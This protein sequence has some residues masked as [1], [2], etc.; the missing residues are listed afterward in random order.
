[1]ID[2]SLGSAE[3]VI[4]VGG[5]AI[6][7]AALL[8]IIGEVLNSLTLSCILGRL[9]WPSL[10]SGNKVFT[11]QNLKRSSLVSTKVSRKKK[12]RSKVKVS[13]GR[14]K[15]NRFTSK[16]VTIS[17]SSPQSKYR[18]FRHGTTLENAIDIY[19]TQLWLAGHSLPTGVYVTNTNEIAKQYSGEDGGIV[20]VD[21]D[22]SV[23]LP[24]V[25]RACTYMRFQML[26]RT[27]NITE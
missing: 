9:S 16:P 21:V 4:A 24:N 6:F 2:S 8:T 15:K 26:N 23:K 12:Y 3:Q 13:A 10:N 1:M 25:I 11:A 18:R 20:L 7:A 22:R 5:I 17:R 19:N 14:A 27:K